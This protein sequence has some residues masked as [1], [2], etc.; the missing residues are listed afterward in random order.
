VG[1]LLPHLVLRCTEMHE[2]LDVRAIFPKFKFNRESYVMF[3]WRHHDYV[4]GIEIPY[5]RTNF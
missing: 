2:I 3:V 5:I 1:E 4:F